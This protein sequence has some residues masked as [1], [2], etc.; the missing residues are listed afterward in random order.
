MNTYTKMVGGGVSDLAL[1]A[2]AF[3]PASL[4]LLR[5]EKSLRRLSR[6]RDGLRQQG[7]GAFLWVPHPSFSRVR[8]FYL[9]DELF[10]VKRVI[11]AFFRHK[12]VAGAPPFAPFAKGGFLPL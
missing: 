2:P 10:A 7:T 5:T 11:T 8:F 9:Q 6:L 1:V 12:R 3:R 4:A